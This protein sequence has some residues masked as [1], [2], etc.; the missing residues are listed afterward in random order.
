MNTFSHGLKNLLTPLSNLIDL[1][2]ALCEAMAKTGKRSKSGKLY[3]TDLKHTRVILETVHDVT[4]KVFSV[5]VCN[6]N[7]QEAIDKLSGMVTD[8]DFYIDRMLTYCHND[9]AINFLKE[10]NL[11]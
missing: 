1:P 11:I 7:M 4:G 8:E 3:P 2:L 6:G 5:M 9:N 10:V